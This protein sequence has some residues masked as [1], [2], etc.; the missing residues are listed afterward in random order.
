MVKTAK[1][2]PL[3]AGDSW[4]DCAPLLLSKFVGNCTARESLTVAGSGSLCGHLCQCSTYCTRV[5]FGGG[6]R[7]A[8]SGGAKQQ[9]GQVKRGEV[10]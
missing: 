2:V 9:A 8:S 7:A 5:I 10:N 1:T 3:C 6:A 4:R